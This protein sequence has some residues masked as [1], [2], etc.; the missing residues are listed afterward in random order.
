MYQKSYRTEKL[1]EKVKVCEGILKN[2]RGK[3][4]VRNESPNN[5]G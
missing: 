5:D 2:Q 1:K 3:S 4:R